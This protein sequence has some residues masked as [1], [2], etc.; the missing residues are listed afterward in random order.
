MLKIMLFDHE[1]MDVIEAEIALS[2][3]GF[4]TIKLTGSYAIL[5]KI[6]FEKPDILLF[7]PDIPNFNADAFLESLRL[8]P[9]LENL[10]IVAIA[11]GEEKRIEEFCLKHD[12]HGYFLK[13][14]GFVD[15]GEFLSQF[16]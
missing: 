10:V 14:N 6:D 12:L 9:K 15:L 3:H 5:P 7:N 4:S 16:L 11:Y 8:E 1:V 13:N 2:K